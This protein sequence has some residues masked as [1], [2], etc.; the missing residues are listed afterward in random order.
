MNL[1]SNTVARS[2]SRLFSDRPLLHYFLAIIITSIAL[3]LFLSFRA[4]EC[5]HSGNEYDC[6]YSP[7]SPAMVAARAAGPPDV[8]W[9]LRTTALISTLH[10]LFLIL[11][12]FHFVCAD[13][14]GRLLC[15]TTLRSSAQHY[16]YRFLDCG[17][18]LGISKFVSLP[19][20]NYGLFFCHVWLVL[21]NRVL[22]SRFS[23]S[24]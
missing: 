13:L 15:R 17:L 2:A 16:W 22:R 5:L 3:S 8:L 19:S 18:D 11:L 6:K 21:W 23:P 14:C 4:Y 12:F 10:G 9:V 20:R 1:E 7:D 24:R